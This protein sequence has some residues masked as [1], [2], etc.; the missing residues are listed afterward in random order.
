MAKACATQSQAL[1][2][3]E[4][5]LKI[6]PLSRSQTRQ[7]TTAD[8]DR[9]YSGRDT[10]THAEQETTLYHR[11]VLTLPAISIQCIS[12]NFL[13][14]L[15][16]L[17]SFWKTLVNLHQTGLGCLVSRFAS[18]NA[19]TQTA[20]QQ[21]LLSNAVPIETS[22]ITLVFTHSQR[23]AKFFPKSRVIGSAIPKL[24]VRQLAALNSGSLQE[25]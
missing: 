24:R 22:A 12:G 10:Q 3:S 8:G 25:Q 20:F 14:I 21:S 5:K 4:V 18:C 15:V 1:T 19:I 16:I 11:C 13:Q 7:A 9:E 17:H 6:Q 23:D 2:M